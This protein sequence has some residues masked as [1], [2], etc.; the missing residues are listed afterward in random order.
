MAVN[1]MGYDCPMLLTRDLI[2]GKWKIL[3]LWHLSKGTKRFSDLMRAIPQITQK[4][5]TEQLKE[6]TSA[7]LIHR[8]VFPEVPLKVE[9]SLTTIGKSIIPVLHTMAAWGDTYLEQLEK[10]VNECS[11]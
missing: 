3:V 11:I 2:G 6:L 1:K 7:S 8:E 9:Y 5:L 10:G 4:V